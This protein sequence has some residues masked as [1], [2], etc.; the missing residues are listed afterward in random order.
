[1]YQP[2]RLSGTD[3]LVNDRINDLLTTATEVRG[4]RRSI[5]LRIGW[6]GRPQPVSGHR[7]L[8]VGVAGN[9]A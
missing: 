2:L 1:M 4:D 6:P 7:P 5:S 8:A 9:R 3:L